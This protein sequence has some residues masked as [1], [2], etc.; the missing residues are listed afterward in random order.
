MIQQHTVNDLGK[1]HAV[2]LSVYFCVFAVRLKLFPSQKK[3]LTMILVNATCSTSK[4]AATAAPRSPGRRWG[5]LPD[6][7]EGARTPEQKSLHSSMSLVETGTRASRNSQQ[8]QKGSPNNSP[9]R[10][11][12]PSLISNGILD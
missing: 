11:L 12:Q 7:R 4:D 1:G 3:F 2:V 5:G 10:N 8:E 6:V 9:H